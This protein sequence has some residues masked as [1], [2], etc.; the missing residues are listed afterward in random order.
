MYPDAII[1][2]GEAQLEDERFDTVKNPSVIIEILSASTRSIDKK[3]KF[4][5]TGKFQP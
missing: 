1:V 5:F 2:C 4:F 3:K